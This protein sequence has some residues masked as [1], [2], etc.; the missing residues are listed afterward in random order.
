MARFKTIIIETGTAEVVNET[1]IKT[2]TLEG[3]FTSTPTIYIVPSPGD[4]VAG[5]RG[6]ATLPSYDV[7]CF[8]SS[9]SKASGVWTFTISTEPKNDTVVQSPA[10]VTSDGT[11][12][13]VKVSWRAIGPTT[14]F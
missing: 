8:V 5:D 13:S 3:I 9:V 7:N 11:Y 2:V 14:A 6:G 12:T 1:G 10:M 4:D